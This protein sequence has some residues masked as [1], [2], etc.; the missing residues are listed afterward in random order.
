MI[1]YVLFFNTYLYYFLQKILGNADLRRSKRSAF[2]SSRTAA[3]LW[4]E[5][6]RPWLP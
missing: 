1:Q 4:S 5:H 6:V 3:S 2:E